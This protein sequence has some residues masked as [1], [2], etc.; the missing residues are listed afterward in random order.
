MLI[1]LR[2]RYDTMMRALQM[3]RRHAPL[4]R[5]RYAAPRF[6]VDDAA[7]RLCAI[8]ATRAAVFTMMPSASIRAARVIRC[9]CY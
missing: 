3:R 9:L 7:A 8:D 1:T 5:T 6:R 2:A 4:I